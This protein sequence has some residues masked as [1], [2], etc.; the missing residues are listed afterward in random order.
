MLDAVIPEVGAKLSDSWAVEDISRAF[1]QDRCALV[2]IHGSALY[3][4]PF[5]ERPLR[6]HFATAHP[7]HVRLFNSATAE[8]EHEYVKFVG[9]R[10]RE[11]QGAIKDGRLVPVPVLAIPADQ[12]AT[13]YA[14]YTCSRPQ[15]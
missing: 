3:P 7:S 1:L 6:L 9:R 10:Q 11:L 12:Q 5:F 8:S 15:R 14:V 2:P 4:S 13:V